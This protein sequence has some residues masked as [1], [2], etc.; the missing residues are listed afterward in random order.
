MWI[1]YCPKTPNN[2]RWEVDV[3]MLLFKSGFTST[4]ILAMNERICVFLYA[5]WYLR[6]LQQTCWCTQVHTTMNLNW[7]IWVNLSYQKKII[8]KKQKHIFHSLLH[9]TENIQTHM[10][11]Y[12]YTWQCIEYKIST[13]LQINVLIVPCPRGKKQRWIN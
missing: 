5:C 6:L 11:M 9:F 10:Y 7:M 8:F 1:I 4:H 2:E 13:S 3:Y 12:K